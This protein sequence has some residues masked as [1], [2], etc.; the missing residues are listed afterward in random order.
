MQRDFLTDDERNYLEEHLPK[1]I[2]LFKDAHEELR[3]E[4]LNKCFPV[5]KKLKKSEFT[6]LLF[7]DPITAYTCGYCFYFARIMKSIFSDLEFVV[8]SNTNEFPTHI[9]LKSKNEVFD[10]TYNSKETKLEYRKA[11]IC[12]LK[13]ITLFFCNMDE[14]MY[15][16]LKYKFY[17]NIKAYLENKKG[18]AY[19]KEKY[20]K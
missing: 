13:Y 7:E 2:E 12:D 17:R 6:S 20:K 11:N 1:V 10:I 3:T 4:L 15:E 5:V 18:Y 19:H 9:F 14:N 8:E 16:K